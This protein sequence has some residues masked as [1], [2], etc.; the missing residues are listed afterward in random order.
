MIS[1]IIFNFTTAVGVVEIT[2]VFAFF[3][4]MG[5]FVIINEQFK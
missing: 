3:F 2:I 4:I 1:D 5:I